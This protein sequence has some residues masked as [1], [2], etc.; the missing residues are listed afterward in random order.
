M[1]GYGIKSVGARWMLNRTGTHC[2]GI[3]IRISKELFY[4]L[5]H[6]DEAKYVKQNKFKK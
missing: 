4:C 2:P 1:T 6:Y 5:K 3:K